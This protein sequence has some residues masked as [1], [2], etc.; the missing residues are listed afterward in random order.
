M[1]IKKFYFI[2]F[3]FIAIISGCGEK[4]DDFEGYKSAKVGS[5]IVKYKLTGRIIKHGIHQYEYSFFVNGVG[6]VDG[7]YVLKDSDSDGF[8]DTVVTINGTTSIAVTEGGITAFPVL[9]ENGEVR[10]VLL[11]AKNL[12]GKKEI[13]AIRLAGASLSDLRTKLATLRFAKEVYFSL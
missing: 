8:V 1:V 4:S 5:E 11:L 10:F 6:E 2:L 9:E 7:V 13:A 3:L 12:E